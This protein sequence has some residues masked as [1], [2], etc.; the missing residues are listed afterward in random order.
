MA[1]SGVVALVF[2]VFMSMSISMGWGDIGMAGRTWEGV[3]VGVF[4]VRGE[5]I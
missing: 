3:K 1:P 5:S 2:V 4:G